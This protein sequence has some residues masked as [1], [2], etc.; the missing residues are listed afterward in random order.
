MN[1][2]QL[3]V[4]W[5]MTFLV[6]ILILFPPLLCK[7]ENLSYGGEQPF[8]SQSPSKQE[9]IFWFDRRN[10]TYCYYPTWRS[11][12]FSFFYPGIATTHYDSV[13]IHWERLFQYTIP[14][15]LVSSLLI[16][17]LKDRKLRKE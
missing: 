11:Y 1:K 6:S 17:T 14:I 2:K 8:S 7:G 12:S 5:L 16:Y 4:L 10:L 13:G 15:L 3:I 9:S